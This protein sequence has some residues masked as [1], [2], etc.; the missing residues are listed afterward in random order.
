LGDLSNISNIEQLTLENFSQD[1]TIFD[2]IKILDKLKQLTL[3]KSPNV[4]QMAELREYC[5]SKNIKLVITE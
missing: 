2:N 4:Q 5:Q 1:I 3:V